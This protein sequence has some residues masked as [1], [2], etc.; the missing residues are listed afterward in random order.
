MWLTLIITLTLIRPLMWLMHFWLPSLMH[1]LLPCITVTNKVEP[2]PLMVTLLVAVP[3]LFVLHPLVVALLLNPLLLAS[4][5]H[6]LV[7]PTH[8]T[9]AVFVMLPPIVSLGVG[10]SLVF[11]LIGSLA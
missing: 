5:A 11:P 2:L 10:I 9:S 1:R 4:L 3:L 6:V 8:P 7:A